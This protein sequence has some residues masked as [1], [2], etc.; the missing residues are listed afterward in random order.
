[1]TKLFDS[2]YHQ[3]YR[4]LQAV[5]LEGDW[6]GNRTDQAALTLPFGSIM[7]FDMQEG[8]PAPYAK[9]LHFPGIRGEIIG[10][11]RGLTNA[12]DFAA[13]GCT[14]WRDDANLNKDWLASPHRI[15]P[16][17]MGKAYGYQWRN[18]EAGFDKETG[19]Q[20][21]ID[22]VQVALDTIRKNPTSRRIVISA[23]RPDH[24]DQ[25]CLPPCHVLYRFQVNVATG[26]L[27]MSMYQ[28]SSDM[29]LGVPMNIAGGAL[30]L[31]LFAAA[32]GLKPRWFTHHL[33]D[34]HIYDKAL[35]AVQ[36]VIN[37]SLLKAEYAPPDLKIR[38][39]LFGAS[40]D[41]LAAIEPHEI[42]LVGYQYHRLESDKVPMATSR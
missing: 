36:E 15:G 42:E 35:G 40:A 19:A 8:F 12:E 14:W 5:L 28:R 21:Y 37:N 10:F 16:G 29:H 9:Y 18:W 31:H 24:F 22:Q 27:N 26:E 39:A 6:Q 23:W 20:I 25:M 4:M 11:L 34:T 3:Y 30:M 17:D 32:T 13:L 1:M 41:E 33:D 7:R 2:S 38:R